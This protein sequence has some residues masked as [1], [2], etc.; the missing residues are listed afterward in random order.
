MIREVRQSD[1][2][3]LKRIHEAQG[4]NYNFP[5][6][7]DEIFLSKLVF[8]NGRVGAAI[9]IRIT[10]EAYLIS[11]NEGTP[12]SRWERFK[13]LHET[14]CQDLVNKGLQDV[15]AWIPPQIEKSFG[16]RLIG[17][18]WQKALWPCYVLELGGRDGSW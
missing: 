7:S 8:E 1:L 11:D 6:L 9:P 3:I 14:V 5:D 13:I 4:F 16:R 10:A 2:E 17:L 12:T 15:H 18:G